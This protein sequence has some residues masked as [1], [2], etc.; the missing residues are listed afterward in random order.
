MPSFT[1]NVEINSS[2]LQTILAANEQVA[3]LKTPVITEQNVVWVAFRPFQENQVSWEDD[4]AVYAS[5]SETRNGVVIKLMAEQPAEPQML[6]PF[7]EGV[8]DPPVEAANIGSGEYGIRNQ[9]F[10]YPALTFGLAQAAQ[11][12][13]T[14]IKYQPL[15]AQTVLRGQEAVFTPEDSI[16]VALM[17]RVESGFVISEVSGTPIV[18][19]FGG[20]VVSITI[21]Y[22]GTA[23]RFVVA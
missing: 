3:I 10:D 1:L 14:V 23:G 22:D 19:K 17:A 9:L 13:G 4:F 8:F 6:Y 7:K 20:D 18:L 11:V 5:G 12:N 16:A 21:K 15:N 2:D